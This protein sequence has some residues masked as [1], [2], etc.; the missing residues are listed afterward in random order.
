[1]DARAISR[2]VHVS[3]FKLRPIADVIR[4]KTVYEAEVWLKTTLS[5]RTTPILKTL[6]SACA[7]AVDKLQ[8][9]TILKNMRIKEIKIDQGPVIKYMKP[10]AQ[11]R[12]SILKKRLSH[13]EIVVEA[14]QDVE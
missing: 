13:I 6:K 1:M 14:N 4:G 11:G 9:K 10:G 2:Y 3:P 5:R 12:S 7:N 8:D